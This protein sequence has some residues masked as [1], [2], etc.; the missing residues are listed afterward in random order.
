MPAKLQVCPWPPAQLALL[1][2]R[3]FLLHPVRL[4][5]LDGHQLGAASCTFDAAEETWSNLGGIYCAFR[6]MVGLSYLKP[7]LPLSLAESTTPAWSGLP[8]HMPTVGLA[9]RH[10]NSAWPSDWKSLGPAAL[11]P[12]LPC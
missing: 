10:V 1:A 6:W 9:F 3:I 7:G 2:G 12:G 4:E 5:V 11:K 8:R